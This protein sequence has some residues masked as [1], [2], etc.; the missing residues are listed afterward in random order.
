MRFE[1]HRLVEGPEVLEAGDRVGSLQLDPLV[2]D[3]ENEDL[4]ERLTRLL[5]APLAMRAAV[6]NTLATTLAELPPDDPRYT[7][8]LRARLERRDFRLILGTPFEG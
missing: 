5:N 3:V 8:A 4:R 7:E 1:L 6:P 2:V